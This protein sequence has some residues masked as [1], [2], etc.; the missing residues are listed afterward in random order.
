LG[1]SPWRNASQWALQKIGVAVTDI[2]NWYETIHIMK[3]VHRNALSGEHD[4]TPSEYLM[5]P[6]NEYQ[7]GNLIDAIAQVDATGDWY[8]EFCDIVAHAMR[9][10]GIAEL[11]SNRG[12]TYTVA[13]VKSRS[14]R[15]SSN[16]AKSE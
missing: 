3:I 1:K 15:K 5:V 4:G 10:M 16:T 9:F 13:D 11:R 12:N 7:M 14:L 2:S 8:G 6:L